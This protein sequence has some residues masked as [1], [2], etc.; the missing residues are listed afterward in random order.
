[1]SKSHVDALIAE[2]FDLRSRHST[3]TIQ[4]ARLHLGRNNDSPETAALI[5]ILEALTQLPPPSGQPTTPNR[6]SAPSHE[7]VEIEAILS[8]TNFASTKTGLVSLLHRLLP[9]VELGIRSKDSRSAVV[10]KVIRA[11]PTLSPEEKASFY[12]ALRR[13]FIAHRDSSLRDWTEII[14]NNGHNL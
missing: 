8:D 1:M 6:Q 10:R 4:S 7:L 13:I 9:G 12:K 5:D 3:Q 14:S 2:L 11:Y